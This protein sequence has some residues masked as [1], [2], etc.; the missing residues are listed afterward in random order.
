MEQICLE[1]TI[2]VLTSLAYMHLF[3]LAVHMGTSLGNLSSF[4]I[5]GAKL[6]STTLLVIPLHHLLIHMVKCSGS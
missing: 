5:W 6:S 3:Q 4:T 2:K 1:L